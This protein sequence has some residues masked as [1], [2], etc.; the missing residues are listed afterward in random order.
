MSL[1]YRTDKAHHLFWK[2]SGYTS[3]MITTYK[4]LLSFQLSNQAQFRLEVIKHFKK[5]GFES[6]KDAFK[7]SRATIYRWT[8]LLS[9]N[10]GSLVK[11]IPKSTRPKRLR[12]METNAGL[13]DY[14]KEERAKHYRLGK[15]KLK[16]FVD[17]YCTAR[18]IETISEST[19]GKIIKRHNLYYSKSNYHLYHDPSSAWNRH[20]VNRKHKVKYCPKQNNLD[21]VQIDTIVKFNDGVKR[22]VYNAIDVNLRF[23]FSYGYYRASSKNTV[24]FFN[25]LESVYPIKEGIKTVQTDNGS[26][27]LA[28]FDNHLRKRGINHLFSYP[29]CPK[30]NGFVERSNRSLQ[31]EF[32][33]Q[34]IDSLVCNLDDFNLK[35]I[36]YLIWFNTIRPHHSLNNVSP[37]KYL[38]K[39]RPESQMYVT[40]TI[41]KYLN[42]I[43]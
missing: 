14:I 36:D 6:T 38:L 37:I 34:N 16:V 27:Y 9:D 5:Y 10:D 21:Y 32:I 25:K 17:D 1:G 41:A 29:R 20:K 43:T 18:N 39:T 13:L 12:R 15:S 8:K 35:L 19:I 7:V 26:E 4:N 24:D 33:N 40:Y 3:D 31:E 11:L 2:V 23:Q 22:Y 30:I 42:R 28:V